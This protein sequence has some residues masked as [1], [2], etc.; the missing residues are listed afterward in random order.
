MREQSG[1]S[2]GRAIEVMEGQRR[3][4]WVAA[5][6]SVVLPGL[7]QVYNGR[8][9]KGVL[10]FCLFLVVVSGS[11]VIMTEYPRAPLN[12]AIPLSTFIA[13]FLYILVDAMIT[14]KRLGSLYRPRAY[15]KWYVYLAAIA[16]VAWVL[17]PIVRDGA[18]QAFKISRGG[19][20]DTLVAG[21]HVLVDRFTY[22]LWIPP[23]GMWVFESR[24]PERGDIIVFR[25]PADESRRFIK[26]V[27]GIPGD[28]V[29]IRTK[30]VYINGEP[31]EEPYALY[32]DPASS[33]PSRA[34]QG[35]YGPATIPKDKLFVLGDN[36]D[37]SQD[38]RF[39]G[40]LARQ[41]IVGRARRIY[42]SWDTVTQR[43]RWERIGQTIR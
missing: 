33:S 35:F 38:S 8:A 11:L 26:R 5:L 43:V 18:V 15:N 28:V 9:K 34:P 30:Q 41:E 23:V 14:A 13:T 39:W 17:Q 40:F 22:G 42:W 19:M 7:G 10:L 3:N 2:W 29:E 27:V 6:L 12:I 4:P 25:D 16:L 31:L 1:T 37:H 21:D 36:R 24:P 20:A 32:T